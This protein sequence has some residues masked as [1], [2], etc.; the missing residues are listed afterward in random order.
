MIFFLKKELI[1]AQDNLEKWRNNEREMRTRAGAN[2]R[3]LADV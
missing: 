1:Y 2:W 3:A